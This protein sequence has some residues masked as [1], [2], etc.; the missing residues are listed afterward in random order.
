MGQYKYSHE[1]GMGQSK[2]SHE[3]GRDGTIEYTVT[4]EG[5]DNS[6]S[7]DGRRDGTIEI[8]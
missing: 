4:S 1:G 6:N 2:Y 7:H 8:Q 3:G 5:W